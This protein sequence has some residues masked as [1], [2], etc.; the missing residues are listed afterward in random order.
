MMLKK[1]LWKITLYKSYWCLE[2]E[3]ALQKGTEG[4]MR[5][6]KYRVSESASA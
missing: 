6:F 1:T 5:G 2:K 4:N 3:A